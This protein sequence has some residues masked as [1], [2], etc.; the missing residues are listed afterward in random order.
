MRQRQLV[1][2]RKARYQSVERAVARG[3]GDSS[4]SMADPSDFS[5]KG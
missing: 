5:R 2:Q 1:A 3:S 4:D